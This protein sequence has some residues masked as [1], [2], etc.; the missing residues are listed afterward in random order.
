MAAW[1]GCHLTPP[2]P[3][4][5]VTPSGLGIENSLIMHFSQMH[6][7]CTLE[8]QMLTIVTCS[9]ENQIARLPRSQG[10]FMPVTG[11]WCAYREFQRRLPKGLRPTRASPGAKS[12]ARP[13][14]EK[15]CSRGKGD[16]MYEYIQYQI[17]LGAQ[18]AVEGCVSRRSE[19][20]NGC[21][22]NVF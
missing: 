12:E 11:S 5:N 21:Y 9:V 2:T 13:Q 15:P 1:R 3:R 19:G 7:F 17:E 18:F 20:G 10:P 8:V 22:S 4:R 14:S 6:Y 16:K